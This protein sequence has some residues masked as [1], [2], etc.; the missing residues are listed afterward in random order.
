MDAAARAYYDRRAPEY[1]DWWH[2]TGLF[3]ARDR[4][5][6]DDA[7][8]GLVAALAGLSPARTLDVACGT[9]FLAR[10]L[11]G[12]VIG[13][14]QSAA[15]AAIARE[16]LPSGIVVLGDALA[17]PFPD[18]TFERLTTAHFY[19]HLEPEQQTAFLR[20]ARR[21]AC[22]V[23]VI[24]SATRPG[25]PLEQRQERVL[26]DGTRH[27]VL[28]RFFTADALAAEVGAREVLHESRWFV[29]VR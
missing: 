14:D 16:R 18:G 28:K 5:G 22:E 10:H 24:D 23:V 6:W 11:P 29:A 9:A 8:A 1:D 7:V 20:E 2:G 26:R 17:L 19:G 21:V 13:F 25:E 27:R 3:A 4:P 15:M 12:L